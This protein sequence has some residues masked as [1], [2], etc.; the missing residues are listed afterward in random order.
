MK[1][2]CKKCKLFVTGTNCP[3]C[4]S[5]QFTDSFKGKRDGYVFKKD[6]LPEKFVD[7][8]FKNKEGL[9]LQ[10][11]GKN[12]KISDTAKH[13]PMY[14]YSLSSGP[15]WV[16]PRYSYISFS[17]FPARYSPELTLNNPYSFNFNP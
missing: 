16:Q 6:E 10:K 11:K 13:F 7:Y 9:I 12:V 3:I 17:V 1:K 4:K 14:F 15:L 8:I 5:N 2:I